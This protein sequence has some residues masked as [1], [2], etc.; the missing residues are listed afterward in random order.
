MGPRHNLSF[1]ACKTAWLAPEL[2]VSMCP[3]PYLRFLQGK[4][5]LLVRNCNSLGSQTSP[6]ILCMQKS[7]FCSRMTS[8]N[9][10]QPSSVVLRPDL[11]VCICPRP[12]LLFWAHITVCLAQEYQDYM[13]SSPNLWF[14]ACKTATLGL[15]FQVSGVQDP[16]CAFCKYNSDFWSRITSL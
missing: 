10:F 1:C 4:Q 14:C 5:R 2:L 16:T 9:G 3:N 8:L 12:H 13:G 11:Q 7:V 6:H 15:E